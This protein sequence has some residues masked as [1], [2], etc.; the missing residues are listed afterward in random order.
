M[1]TPAIQ[2]YIQLSWL[3]NSIWLLKHLQQTQ[4]SLLAQGIFI[5][6]HCCQGWGDIE[7]KGYRQTRWRS[8]A[9]RGGRFLTGLQ[10]ANRDQVV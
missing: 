2:G 6:L 8:L 3:K 9:V 7:A 1:P 5:H 4:D 10:S